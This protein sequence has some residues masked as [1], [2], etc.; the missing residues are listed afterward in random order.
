MT[1]HPTREE[2]VGYVHQ[3]LPNG[4]TGGSPTKSVLRCR[5]RELRDWDIEVDATTYW[6]GLSLSDKNDILNNVHSTHWEVARSSLNALM[7]PFTAESTLRAPFSTAYQ[8]PHN[9]AIVGSSDQHAVM[10]IGVGSLDIVPLSNPD[11][12]FVHNNQLAGIVELKTWWKV[13]ETQINDVRTGKLK[14]SSI[15]MLIIT[16]CDPLQGPHHGRLAVEQTY[17]YMVHD[18]IL[19]GILSTYNAFVF[20][21]R[22]RPGILYMSRFIPNNSNSPTIMKLIYFFSHLCARDVGS[23]PEMDAVGQQITLTRADNDTRRAPKI[24]DSANTPSALLPPVHL[25]PS[26]SPRR[27]PR[28]RSAQDYSL[29]IDSPTLFL[30]I[31]QRGRGAYLGCKGWRGTL[32]TGHIVFVKLWDAWKYSRED[33]D[34]EASIYLQLGDLWGTTIPEYLGSGDWGFCHVL[35]LSYIEV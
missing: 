4:G 22:E 21:K 32:S 16:G 17:G 35:L 5:W 27:S 18:K 20:M 28:N 12:I 7:E 34:H 26:N 9:L 33:C 29:M 23:Y 15:M 24:P 8:I 19:F 13:D 3:P 30:D 31:D 11:L 10:R 25:S 14:R 1:S 2:F 6:E